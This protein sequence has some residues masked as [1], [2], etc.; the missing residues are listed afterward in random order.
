MLV[1]SKCAQ[2]NPASASACSRCG[3]RL[4]A[5]DY[6]RGVTQSTARAPSNGGETERP[7][8][9]TS[10]WGGTVV[11]VFEARGGVGKTTVA[12]NL[13]AALAG[14]GKRVALVDLDLRFGD[15]AIL[16][17]IPV[18]RSIADLVLAEEEISWE[19]LQDC[20]YKHNTGVTILPAPVRPTDPGN[21]RVGQIERV[22][23]LFAQAYDY[24]ILDTP[25]TYNDIVARSL[26]LAN[27]ALLVTTPDRTTLEDTGRALTMLR[28]WGLDLNKIRLVVVATNGAS[29]AEPR[30]IERAL[31]Y[32]VVAA[33]PYDRRIST[34]KLGS[35]LVLSHPD[36][37]AARSIVRLADAIVSTTPSAVSSITRSRLKSGRERSISGDSA[38]GGRL[39]TL[40]EPFASNPFRTLRLTADASGTQIRQTIERIRIEA[41]LGSDPEGE[42]RL[43]AL[44]K[45]QAELLD[46]S[47]R[48][49]HEVLWFYNPPDCL[50]DGNL[51]ATDQ[52]LAR[53]R[54]DGEPEESWQRA[55]DLALWLL[56]EAAQGSDPESTN[57]WTIRALSAW[58]DAA[59]DPIYIR[60]LSG[61]EQSRRGSAETIWGLGVGVLAASSRRCMNAD[62]LDGVLAR[63]RG[64]KSYGLEEADLTKMVE[65]AIEIAVLEGQR[66]VAE[67]RAG[68]EEVADGPAAARSWA[69]ELETALSDQMHLQD[70]V[71]DLGTRELAKV[72]DEAAG[73]IRG[74]AI[75]LHNARDETKLASE[76]VDV[77]LRLAVSKKTVEQ[78]ESDLGTLRGLVAVGPLAGVINRAVSAIQDGADAGEL[79]E[80][81]RALYESLGDFEGDEESAEGALRSALPVLRAVAIRLHNEYSET[82]DAATV[83]EWCVE[84]ADDAE[85]RER[86]NSDHRQLL[87]Q[88]HMATCVGL[89]S[90]KRWEE[91]EGAARIAYSY[92]DSVDDRRTANEALTAI[93][94]RRNARVGRA[95]AGAAIAAVVVGL[96]VWGA[97]AGS[98]DGS[99]GSPSAP[100]PASNPSNSSNSSGLGGI[101]ECQNMRDELNDKKRTLDSLESQIDSIEAQY[102]GSTLPSDVYYRYTSLIDQHNSLVRSYNSLLGRLDSEC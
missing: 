18:E 90:S 77:A 71:S 48:I 52:A 2:D 44:T 102:P 96:I 53:F 54:T 8:P 101:T 40:Q 65:P 32:E 50:Y 35:L 84:L 56:V 51:E 10:R 72:L 67:A 1:C 55:H 17:D 42:S 38:A 30:E 73:L 36:S 58:N 76:L 85:E 49:Q 57:D 37:G 69:E 87:Y 4:T 78:L 24:V 11:T 15:V 6:A 64:A 45:A 7:T 99:S 22:V 100:P 3:T 27:T 68:S 62:D 92:A 59:R 43:D 14:T 86:F 34:M 82:A 46:P 60:H 66:K 94:S 31:G 26:E 9:P 89:V 41:R 39:S 97:I 74:V 88:M 29:R 98:D 16:M 47:K 21:V 81:A 61:S 93:V 95:I 20:V 80:S 28:E 63:Y 70:E 19:I 79:F 25:G 91:A 23:T 5:A 13:A 75:S 33:V 12:I 83:M